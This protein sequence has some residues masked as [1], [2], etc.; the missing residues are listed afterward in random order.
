M[1]W[2]MRMGVTLAVEI[3]MAYS[4]DYFT[5]VRKFI[6]LF[7]FQF[8]HF[9]DPIGTLRNVGGWLLC[10]TVKISSIYL[11]DSNS[12]QRRPDDFSAFRELGHFGTSAQD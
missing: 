1:S 8:H 11:F 10:S 3:V 5:K 12:P 2:A 4:T 9:I 7:V 6:N